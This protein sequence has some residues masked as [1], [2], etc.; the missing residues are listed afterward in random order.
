MTFISYAQNFE[1]VM[2]RRALKHVENGFYIDVGAGHPDDYSVTR[3]FYDRGWRGI[4]IEPTNRIDRLAGAR[5]RDLN[6][7]AAVGHVPD[8]LTLFV[9]ED[10]KDISTLD[11]A[12]AQGH[13]TAGWKITES[14][15]PVVTLADICRE[16][17]RSE[18]S[19]LKIDVEGAEREV[20]FGADFGQ[21]RPWIVV[22]EATA[23]NSQVPT[24]ADWEELL[25]NAD[26]RF[27]WFDGLNRFYIGNER[28]EHLSSAFTAPPNVFDDFIRATD[29]EH[30]NKIVGAEARAAGAETRLAQANAR[31]S[32]ADRL[33]TQAETRAVQ[34]EAFTQAAEARA[35]EAEARAQSSKVQA[36]EAVNRAARTEELMAQAEARAV[37]AETRA[38]AAE[39]HARAAEAHAARSDASLSEMAARH[40]E[41]LCEIAALRT[42]TSWRLS[43]PLRMVRWFMSAHFGAALMEAGISQD[44][45]ER[46]KTL[47]ASVVRRT[48]RLSPVTLPGQLRRRS[49][50]RDEIPYVPQLT[51]PTGTRFQPSSAISSTVT[52]SRKVHQFH[53]GSWPGDAVTNSMLLIQ[54]LLRGLGYTSDIFVEHRHPEFVDRFLQI[55]D[56][57]HHGDYILIVHHS[58]GYDA[59]ERITSLP[60]RKILLYHNIT[61]PEFLNDFPE[62]IPYAELG[63]RQLSVL[64]PY[65]AA[66]LADSEFNAL[67]LR[68]HGYDL[69]VACQFLLDV[70]RLIAN[71]SKPLLHSEQHLFTVL[72]VGRVVASKGQA[73]LIDAFAE[74]RRQWSAPCRL[75]LIGRM[76]SPD[77][78]Y[79]REIRRRICQHNLQDA[80]FL[81]GPISDAELWE[82]YK[83]ADL[84]VSLSLHEG[85]GVPLVE[86]MAHGIPVLAWPAGAIPYTLD[87]C[88]ELLPDRSP[89]VVAAAML[90]IAR[91]PGLHERI[92]V[93]QREAL[94][95]F[96]LDRQLP[97]LT[98]GPGKGGRSSTLRSGGTASV[99][100]ELALHDH[101]T[102]HRN[103]QPCRN[104]SLPR[105]VAGGA[106]PRGSEIRAL[107]KRPGRRP[108][109][110]IDLLD[111]AHGEAYHQGRTRDRA[112]SR[113][114]PPLSR[115]RSPSSR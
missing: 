13:R 86:A 50:G 35:T 104:Q 108:I 2:L 75:V 53:A 70:D 9:V 62:Y 69:P 21:F 12:I 59:C 34:A 31:A 61:P 99:R 93:R 84:Y 78:A 87:G 94:G 44:R 57:P 48:S 18:I 92:V 98:S 29:T 88:G 65:M 55:D 97:R 101:R 49:V 1:D 6:I 114:K 73:D 110:R 26:Y 60:A 96:R 79:P 11:P 71:A 39:T 4:N 109:F 83:A 15:V 22:I 42:S 63:R 106:I 37:A 32:E 77:A 14:T 64:R 105:P 23:P 45:V 107:G 30:L 81:T 19:F 16:H 24:H 103:V 43:A 36:L 66:A 76:A 56:L 80:V 5:P 90:R 111:Y 51:A 100:S 54:R 25:T 28:W 8:K 40:N 102:C 85:F 17:V 41:A 52:Y 7:Q 58:M 46:L 47:T 20:L 91:D 74:F 72:F 112:R 89:P 95:R 82:R 68:K 38:L 3:A 33:A 67:E 113:Y 27:A 10:N 115:I